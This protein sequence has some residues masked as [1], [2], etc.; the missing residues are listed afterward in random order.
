MSM[1]RAIRASI[2]EVGVSAVPPIN[3]SNCNN[4]NIEYT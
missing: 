1:E 3:Y 4:V 2:D